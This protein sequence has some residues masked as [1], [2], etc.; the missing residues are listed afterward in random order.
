MLNAPEEAAM[1]EYRDV[2]DAI[3]LRQLAHLFESVGWQ[4]RTRDPQRLA[5]MVR[6]SMY[7][8]SAF[9]GG[10]LVG[11][12]RAISDGAFNAYV[13]TVAVLPA[14]QRRGI[15]RELVRRLV[16]GRDHIQFVLHADPDVHPFYA[17]CGF[18]PATDMLR[19]DRRH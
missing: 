3:D 4:H 7:D 15:G 19:R 13:S 2:S 18:R 14:Y 11:Y 16:E 17:R 6:G 9:D 1:I 12:A 5:Q 8:V 10:A